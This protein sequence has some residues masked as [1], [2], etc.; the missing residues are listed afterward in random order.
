MSN[1]KIH[2]DPT[3]CHSNDV[4]GGYD[5]AED[6]TP[7]SIACCKV[8]FDILNRLG[9]TRIT[10]IT[11]RQTDGRTDIIIAYAAPHY[12]ARPKK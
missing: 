10:S 9:V 2:L 6:R 1:R 12:V 3:Q 4:A 8:C 5:S 11:D 7:R